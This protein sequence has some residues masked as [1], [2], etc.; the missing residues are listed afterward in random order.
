MR[1][2]AL[3]WGRH[4]YLCEYLPTAAE[5]DIFPLR[6]ELDADLLNGMRGRVR[7]VSRASAWWAPASDFDWEKLY[8]VVPDLHLMTGPIASV[9]KPNDPAGIYDLQAE[10]D[11]LRFVQSLVRIEHLRGKIKAIQIGDS[12]D[13]WVGYGMVWRPQPNRLAIQ[14]YGDLTGPV[15]EE[16]QPL[17][18]AN[19]TRTVELRGGTSWIRQWIR[20]IQGLGPLEARQAARWQSLGIGNGSRNWVADLI[21]WH[22]S[23]RRLMQDQAAE[24]A[25]QLWAGNDHD[26]GAGVEVWLNPAEHALRLLERHCS[27][28]FIYGNHDNYLILPE[29]CGDAGIAARRRNFDGARGVFIEHAHRMEATFTQIVPH[30]N[31]GTTGGYDATMK[32]YRQLEQGGAGGGPLNWVATKWASIH[33]Q[34]GYYKEFARVWMGRYSRKGEDLTPPHIFVIGHTHIPNLFC[35]RIKE[36]LVEEG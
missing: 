28:E 21:Y 2:F 4:A 33:D 14:R 5:H 12:H 22:V 24:L 7:V 26:Y 11:L 13:L 23:Q 29:V 19:D 30:N 36:G 17:F 6:P 35:I 15:D 10:L 3:L 20:E 32:L 8:V 34:P 9:W 18:K 25:E 27:L 1:H 31:D 16:A